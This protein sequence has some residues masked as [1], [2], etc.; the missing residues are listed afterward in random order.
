M[1]P[2]NISYVQGD[3][4][5]QITNFTFSDYNI[6][7]D[8]FDGVI[9]YKVIIKDFKT[10]INTN[11]VFKVKIDEKEFETTSISFDNNNSQVVNDNVVCSFSYELVVDETNENIYKFNKLWI[12][13]KN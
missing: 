9:K 1:T 3:V 4:N 10:Q 2:V 11:L 5:E 13:I 8:I 6:A 7:P 12:Y